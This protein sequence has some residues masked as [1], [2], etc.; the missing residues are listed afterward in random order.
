MFTFYCPQNSYDQL[1]KYLCL[2]PVTH[3]APVIICQ[4]QENIDLCFLSLSLPQCNLLSQMVQSSQDNKPFGLGGRGEGVKKTWFF[5]CGLD[6]RKL[7]NRCNI[8]DSKHLHILKFY[9]IPE[10]KTYFKKYTTIPHQMRGANV[11]VSNKQVIALLKGFK[12]TYRA[13]HYYQEMCRASKGSVTIL[14]ITENSNSQDYCS[15]QD[16]QKAR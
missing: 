4:V 14:E 6:E 11:I 8:C 13:T 12:R 15:E 2:T 7:G 9:L 16:E 5:L 3:Q 1:C 10:N